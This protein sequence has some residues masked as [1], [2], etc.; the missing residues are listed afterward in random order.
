[1]VAISP[2]FSMRFSIAHIKELSFSQAKFL[3]SSIIATGVDYALFFL[4]DWLFF[5]P[6]TAHAI[7][8][9]IAV[10]VN[11]YLQ[12]RFIFDLKRSLRSA[13]AIS[14]IFS[15]IGWGL[16]VAMMYFL[17]KIPL[18]SSHPVLAKIIVTGILF[19]FNFFTKRY[20]FEKRLFSPNGQND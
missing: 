20:A 16:G 6:V 4:L 8:Y 18:F 7:S 17:V 2:N 11:F 3:T 13:F 10:V 15:A 9:P 12:K 14:M 19:F 5:G 1:M